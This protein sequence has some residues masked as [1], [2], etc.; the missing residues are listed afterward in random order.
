MRPLRW[1]LLVA[2]VF[3]CGV[4]AGPLCGDLNQN[5]VVGSV[6]ALALRQHLASTPA[7]LVVDE[8]RATGGG[9]ADAVVARLAEEG[10]G[11]RLGSVRSADTY[12]P[13]GPAAHAVLVSAD[14]VVR[15]GQELMR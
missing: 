10:Y 5:R 9:V 3:P 2:A 14:D 7:V 1:L 6:D 8:C 4:A 15:S 12:V 13:L 11:G